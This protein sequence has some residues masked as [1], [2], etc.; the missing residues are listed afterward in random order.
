[1][2]KDSETVSEP[3][4]EKKVDEEPHEPGDKSIK[5]HAHAFGDGVTAADCG[6]VTFVEVAELGSNR[7]S[8]AAPALNFLEDDPGSVFTHLHRGGT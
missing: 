5:F 8:F 1:M 2:H 6:H 4:Q 3:D 7:V